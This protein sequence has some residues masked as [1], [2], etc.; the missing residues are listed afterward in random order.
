MGKF[1][2]QV[3]LIAHWSGADETASGERS[4]C[5]QSC[6]FFVFGFS[7]PDG[8]VCVMAYLVLAFWR[9]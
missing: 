5:M 2:S 8:A 4:Q 3:F 6:S 9:T 7:Q 1:T